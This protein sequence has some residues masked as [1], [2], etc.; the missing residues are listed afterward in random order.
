MEVGKTFQR[1]GSFWTACEVSE[2]SNKEFKWLRVV[3]KWAGRGPLPRWSK[4]PKTFL[5]DRRRKKDGCLVIQ[6]ELG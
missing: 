5:M 4:E 2:E 1:Y 3:A 6:P